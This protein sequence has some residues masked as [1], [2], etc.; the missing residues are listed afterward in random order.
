[1]GKGEISW[2]RETEEGE[3]FQVYA[4]LFGSEWT[5]YRRRKRF[6]QWQELEQPPLE[7]WLELLDGVERRVA[8]RMMP[9][10]EMQRVRRLI[11][12]QY[13]DWKPS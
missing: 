2:N 6:D 13:P 10:A 11:R 3:E 1:M 12:E 9:P 5:F 8:R 4:R 7:D